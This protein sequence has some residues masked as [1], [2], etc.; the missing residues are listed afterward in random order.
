MK[1]A[2]LFRPLIVLFL[3]VAVTVLFYLTQS[4]DRQRHNDRLLVMQQLKRW[5]ATLSEDILRVHTGLLL[6]YDTLVL[7]MN[8][9]RTR[10]QELESGSVPIT[11][12]GEKKLEEMITTIGAMITQKEEL[13]EQFKSENSVLQ[14]S[15]RFFP[16]GIQDFVKEIQAE[17]SD[18]LLF[19]PGEGALQGILLYLHDPTE[20]RKVQV[21]QALEVLKNLGRKLSPGKRATLENLL[22]HANLI[23][24]TKEKLHTIVPELLNPNNDRTL[25]EL[26]RA[27]TD[28]QMRIDQYADTFRMGLYFMSVL[29]VLYIGQILFRL[30]TARQALTA[31]NLDLEKQVE[32]RTEEISLANQQ[33]RTEILQKEKAQQVAEVARQVADRANRAKSIFIANMSHE[34][35]TPLNGILGYAQILLRDPR[36]TGKQ[37]GGVEVIQQG[38]E[39]L[40]TLVN[41]VLD[42]SKIEAQKVELQ[43]TEFH[44]PETLN[45]ISNQA[46][47]QLE[48][49]GLEFVF[50]PSPNL[51]NWVKA[52][53]K[54]MKQIL[55]NLLSNAGKFTKKGH[56]TLRAEMKFRRNG[57][58]RIQF[59]VEDTGI[60]IESHKFE[61]IF[62]PFQQVGDF[63]EP[64]EGAGL[65]LALCRQLV[66]LMGGEIQITSRPGE[67]SCFVV[68]LDLTE[69]APS[70]KVTPVIDQGIVGYQGSPRHILVV[71]DKHENRQ[72]LADFLTPL[73]FVIAESSDGQDGISKALN[74]SYD[75]MLIDYG[76]P[77]M[78][79]VEMVGH[80]RNTSPSFQGV[81]IGLSAN[82]LDQTREEFLKAGCHDFLTKPIHFSE[83][84]NQLEK[85]LSLTWNYK[86]FEEQPDPTT[87]MNKENVTPKVCQLRELLALAQKGHILGI[88]EYVVQLERQYSSDSRAIREILRLAESFNLKKLCEYLTVSIQQ[89]EVK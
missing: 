40:L 56:V 2:R 37:R 52:D 18:S 55:Q 65:G 10:F 86:D 63:R 14:N 11:E 53:P 73:G 32:A 60:G 3:L 6:H 54:R 58:C 29:L 33:L 13:L 89:G 69:V 57:N 71:D 81:M 27:Y 12:I 17:K 31:A 16:Q 36:L 51:P 34:F 19:R 62:L 76:L 38:G 67:G 48:K 78:T 68:L 20:I 1:E 75:L 44:L 7:A 82:A 66:T 43:P 24:S 28:H 83:L 25:D 35:R 47:R 79:G 9:I 15:A 23:L 21:R 26:I 74:F 4:Y 46:K 70:E 8:R 50:E 42:L 41:D 77:G 30:Q 5:E 64:I 84:L 72:V 22:I 61:E 45:D 88:R 49:K 39:Q 85:Y 80:L 59:E 87:E